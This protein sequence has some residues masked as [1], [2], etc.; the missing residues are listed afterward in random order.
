MALGFGTNSAVASGFRLD[1]KPPTPPQTQSGS[2]T[3]TTPPASNLSSSTSV[4]TREQALIEADRFLDTDTGDPDR[5]YDTFWEFNGIS[6]R[7]LTWDD[8]NSLKYYQQMPVRDDIPGGEGNYYKYL[9]AAALALTPSGQDP[10][11]MSRETVATMFEKGFLSNEYDGRM[12]VSIDFSKLSGLELGLMVRGLELQ[13][14]GGLGSGSLIDKLFLLTD[15][16]KKLLGE[17]AYHA[18]G[19]DN[20]GNKDGTLQWGEIK[21]AIAEGL[22]VATPDGLIAGPKLK[23]N[24]LE[25]QFDVAMTDRNSGEFVLKYWADIA[26]HLK[27]VIGVEVAE[28]SAGG[29]NNFANMM[30]LLTGRSWA[31]RDQITDL[32]DQGLIYANDKG[33]IGIDLSKATGAQIESMVDRL[34]VAARKQTDSPLWDALPSELKNMSD[35][36]RANWNH[37]TQGLLNFAINQTGLVDAREFIDDT[38]GDGDGKVSGAE[39][40][41]AI[42]AGDLVLTKTGFDGAGEISDLEI[43]ARQERILKLETDA[44]DIFDN[45]G[46]SEGSGTSDDNVVAVFKSFMTNLGRFGRTFRSVMEISDA[47]LTESEKTKLKIAIADF[48]VDVRDAMQQLAE[49]AQQNSI[50]VRTDTPEPPKTNVFGMIT[51][52]LGAVSSIALMTGT[53]INAIKGP[54]VPTVSLI[55]GTTTGSP[56]NFANLFK[57]FQKKDPATL[58]DEIRKELGD[59]ALHNIRDTLVF[60]KEGGQWLNDNGLTEEAKTLSDNIMGIGHVTLRSW[61]EFVAADAIWKITQGKAI[62]TSD[63]Y[64]GKFLRRDLE[65]DEAKAALEQLRSA[66]WIVSVEGK[67]EKQTGHG[68]KTGY[69]GDPLEFVSLRIRRPG[70]IGLSSEAEVGDRGDEIRSGKEIG[71]SHPHYNTL[72]NFRGAVKEQFAMDLTD[73]DAFFEMVF[74]RHFAAGNPDINPDPPKY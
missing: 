59:D 25:T 27:N 21:T 4:M 43:D 7:P 42:D 14:E 18:D 17:M 68:V 53:G 54:S 28:D 47:P 45:S 24:T 50:N 44:S 62:D 9:K 12:D 70:G 49:Q 48:Q 6:E 38:H 34:Q 55:F 64:Q 29:A 58:D 66:G 61:Q 65:S 72:N 35:T 20:P 52:V 19:P 13:G 40:R 71:H 63:S 1:I 5:G 41:A 56:N 73:L 39:Y 10:E 46:I 26:N 74:D 36:E 11:I 15:D 69:D 8:I 51:G 2:G 31:S 57:A 3:T 30:A 23:E 22:L 33:E 60:L 16:Q 37:K 67:G 32:M